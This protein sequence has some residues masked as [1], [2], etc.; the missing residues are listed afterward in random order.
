MK[1]LLCLVSGACSLLLS[2]CVGVQQVRGEPSVP[3]VV[4]PPPA[5]P[6][7]LD[8]LVAPIALY[9]DAL[10]ALILPA[11]T[12]SSDVVLAARY[13][14]G[15]GERTKLDE[16]PWEDSVK[17]LAHYPDVVKWMDE[18]LAWTQRLGEAYLAEPQEVMA[19]IQRDRARARASGVLVD[20]EQQQVV[21]EEGN[22]RI[23]PAQPEVIYVPRYD[24]RIVYVEQPVYYSPDPWITFGLGFGVGSWLAYDCDWR[25]RTIWVHH[26]D[27]RP[28]RWHNRHRHDWRY[29]RFADR[30][31]HAHPGWNRWKPAPGRIV[32]PHRRH[33]PERFRGVRPPLPIA[34]APHFDRDRHER[35]PD[36]IHRDGPQRGFDRDR[37]RPGRF[38]DGRDHRQRPGHF[39][40]GRDHRT[41]PSVRRHEPRPRPAPAMNPA[42][43]PAR[44]VDANRVP[45]VHRSGPEGGGRHERADMQRGWRNVPGRSEQNRFSRVPAGPRREHHRPPPQAAPAAS[46]APA[47]RLAAPPPRPQ[48]RQA[49]VARQEPPAVVRGAAPAP[50]APRV[51]RSEHRSERGH[52]ERGGGGPRG[53]RHGRGGHRHDN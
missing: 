9:P 20:T 47:P 21:L 23:I 41:P 4:A 15:G 1:T 42:L 19:A 44:G 32:P 24:P 5:E 8:E 49:P 22:I 33:H 45:R 12:I 53:G 27:H 3:V 30:D 18:N 2:G 40:D 37:H 31:R 17:S 50:S 46:A 28:A 36:R 52:G 48:V 16:Q 6:G 34:G 7:S 38:G 39:G 25:A 10:V 43:G 13:L 29:P 11:S 35:R 51:E 26:H 14:A